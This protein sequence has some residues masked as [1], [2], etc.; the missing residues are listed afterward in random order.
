MA[1]NP[2]SRRGFI[3]GAVASTVAARAAD[4][5]MSKGL[6][7]RVLG[8]TGRRVPMLAL[9]C[10]SR[11]IMYEEEDRGVEVIDMALRSGITYLDTA[12]S[13]GN[14][15]SESWI[16]KAIKGRRKG[17][18]LATK[19]QARTADEVLRRA[20]ESLK[21]MGVDQVDLLHLHSLKDPDDLETVQ[22]NGVMEALYK[23]REQGLARYI[24]IT[25]H[26]DPETLAEALRRYDVDCTQMAL[27]AALQGMQ[28]GPGKMVINPV[29]STSFEKVALPVANKKKLGVIAMKVFAQDDI[30]SEDSP[31]S[32]LLRYALSLP[33][34]IVTVGVP[35]H[36]YLQANLAAARSF[37][38]MPPKEMKEFSHRMAARYKIALDRRFAAH[39]DV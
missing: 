24:G 25:S 38:P 36:E 16:G 21:R 23:V 28:S 19:T 32:K 18:F 34:S 39:L 20:E 7:T 5:R 10:G 13:Y 31:P 8:R 11:L 30:I 1:R 37:T 2:I 27:N 15:R 12:Q 6:P 22:K 29:R 4:P 33:V 9:G 3:G 17:L 35:K 14:G 26:T